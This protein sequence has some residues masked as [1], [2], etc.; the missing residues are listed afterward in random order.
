MFQ[1]KF[2]EKIKTQLSLSTTF[3]RKSCHL[4]DNVEKYGT[5]GQATD[6]NKIRRMRFACW[7]PKATHT[8]THARTHTQLH[9]QLTSAPYTCIGEWL[10]SK[11]GRFTFGKEHRYQM[12]RSFNGPQYQS[13][14]FGEETS[15]TYWDFNPVSS[16]PLDCRYTDYNTPAGPVGAQFI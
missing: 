4:W 6:N 15:C 7:I 3:S 9:K 16:S 1:I 11:A 8:H 10:S 5:S 14:H 2:V 12:N 13:G